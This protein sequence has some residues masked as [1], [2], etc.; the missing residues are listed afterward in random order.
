MDH[1]LRLERQL[2]FALYSATRAMTQAYAPLLA[3]LGL[4]YPQYLVML[5]LWEADDLA[6]KELGARLALD[7]GTLTP[8]LKRLEG[9]G[10]VTRERDADDERVVRARLTA[11]G[12]GLRRRAALIPQALAC[13]TGLPLRELGALRDRL[14]HL[15][16]NL[17]AARGGAEPQ[18]T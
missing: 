1:P 15:T 13:Q 8:L 10:L 3:P 7:S 18:E 17:R 14:S 12:R 2:C 6:V 4:T 5:V 11:R 16:Q 9:L